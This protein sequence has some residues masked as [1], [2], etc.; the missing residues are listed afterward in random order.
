[1]EAVEYIFTISALCCC[2]LKLRI[3]YNA[4]GNNRGCIKLPLAD[5]RMQNSKYNLCLSIIIMF[6][7]ITVTSN[8]KSISSLFSLEY[9]L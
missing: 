9:G 3:L 7:K 8:A 5:C 1:M 6:E 2:M 4:Y